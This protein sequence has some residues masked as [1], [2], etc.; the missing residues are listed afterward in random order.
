MAMVLP[1][2]FRNGRNGGTRGG[3][4]SE[5]LETRK[6]RTYRG[7]WLENMK[8]RQNTGGHASFFEGVCILWMKKKRK[9]F[10]A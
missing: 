8:I 2:K 9:E 7:N 10:R 4:C 3:T 1:D 5:V 6:R